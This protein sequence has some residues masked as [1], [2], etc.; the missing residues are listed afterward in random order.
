MRI[1]VTGANGFIASN[2]YPLLTAAG[3]ESVALI[4][5]HQSSIPSYVRKITLDEL[6]GENFD[7]VINLAGANIAAQRWSASRKET[8][9]N[10]RVSFTKELFSK[11]TIKPKVLLNASA[12]GY[13]G[14]DSSKT[15][16]EESEPNG[17]FT[18]ELCA[19]WEQ[20]AAHLQDHGVRTIIFR[21][22]VVLGHGGALAKMK[23]PFQMGL[24][25]KIA[26]GEQFFPWIHIH[27]VCRFLVTAIDQESYSGHYNLV[28]PQTITQGQ[29]ATA[30]AD[31][32]NR[33]ALFT[34]PSWLL[35]RIF[36]E[37]SCLLTQGQK[38]IPKA[39]EEASF[40][41]EF[42]TIEYALKDLT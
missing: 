37:M 7:V 17:G 29:F 1:L 34:T 40:N 10:S 16:S 23:L 27:D 42:P 13:Y 26:T 38:V 15:F 5:K 31:A 32:L 33:P 4:H 28:A 2:L 6:P 41:F 12:V 8:L 11:L 9:F 22:G 3:Y 21:L 25:G 35:E 36:G 18:H 19:A 30:Y 39:L 24:G 20:E 14:F